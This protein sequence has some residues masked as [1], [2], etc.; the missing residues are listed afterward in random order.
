MQ[1]PRLRTLIG[2]AADSLIDGLIVMKWLSCTIS[3]DL[4]D[5]RANTMTEMVTHDIYRFDDY[6]ASPLLGFK[7]RKNGAEG[8]HYTS[9]RNPKSNCYALFSPKRV[10]ENFQT[11][12]YE[13]V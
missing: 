2:M 11:A 3:G 1:Q 6:R 9:V 5:I 4:V 7:H 8:L 10:E 13:D 12:H